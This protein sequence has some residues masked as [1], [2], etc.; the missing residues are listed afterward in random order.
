MTTG[1]VTFG[2]LASGLDVNLIIDQLTN[3]AR[4]PIILAESRRLVLQ[5]QQDAVSSIN[6]SMSTLLARIASLKDPT[7]VARAA[8]VCSRRSRRP[9]PS[10]RRRPRTPR[11]G[12]SRST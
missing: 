12:R 10:R 1:P 5:Q 9:T 11:S 2:G 8:R 7:I 4:R 3:L 6:G